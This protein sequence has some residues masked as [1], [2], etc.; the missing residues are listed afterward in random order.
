MKDKGVPQQRNKR[1]ADD[2]ELYEREKAEDERRYRRYLETGEYISH[3]AMMFWLNELEQAAESK[4][5]TE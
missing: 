4:A 2:K 1:V 5:T 3:E